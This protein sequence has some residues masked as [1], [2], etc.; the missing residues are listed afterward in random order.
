VTIFAPHLAPAIRSRGRRFDVPIV[1]HASGAAGL[2][3][4]RKFTAG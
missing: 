3:A 1:R 2:S 4:R